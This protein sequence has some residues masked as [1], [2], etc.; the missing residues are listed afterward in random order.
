MSEQT[1]NAERIDR[2]VAADRLNDLAGELRDGENMTV[3]VG[4]KNIALTPPETVDYRIDVVEKQSRF[5]GDRETV[6]I[7]IDWKPE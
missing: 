2:G 6:R 7:E 3:R 5:R 4:N 1:T